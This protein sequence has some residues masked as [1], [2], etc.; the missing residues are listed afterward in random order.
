MK[1]I[2]K[3]SLLAII[4]IVILVALYITYELKFKDYDIADTEV[5]ALVKEEFTIDLPDGTKMIVDGQGNVIEEIKP[6]QEDITT[7]TID[8]ENIIR[9]SKALKLLKFQGFTAF[10][11]LW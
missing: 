2:W 6:V 10:I 7:Y 8:E 9:H 4:S 5:D 3:Y 1:K 11:E